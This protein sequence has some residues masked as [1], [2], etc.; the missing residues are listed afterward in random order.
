MPPKSDLQTLPRLAASI[1]VLDNIGH[2]L[3][4]ILSAE[5]QSHIFKGEM[6][7]S[8]HALADESMVVAGD[9]M[10]F[11]AVHGRVFSPAPG[12]GPGRVVTVMA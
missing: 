10:G 5:M 2:G 3:K 8:G 6:H 1:A 9:E 12:A 7:A 4:L 11:A